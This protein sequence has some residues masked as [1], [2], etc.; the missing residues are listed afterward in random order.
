MVIPAG[1]TADRAPT[2]ARRPLLL[3][4]LDYEPWFTLN[5]PDEAAV[6]LAP[7]EAILA[8]CER[9][10]APAS[11]F[12]DVL[13]L[14]RLRE[15]GRGAIADAIAAQLRQVVG[16]GHDLQ[17]HL[18]PHWLEAT[19]A[20]GIW[21]FPARKFRLDE[22]GMQAAAVAHRTETLAR[23]GIACL[24]AAIEDPAYPVIAFRAGGYAIQPA[25]RAVLQGLIA[26]GIRIDSSVV[27]GMRK[28]TGRQAV[29]F[30]AAPLQ[31]N[32]RVGPAG[33]VLAPAAAGLLEV[34]VAAARLGPRAGLAQWRHFRRP[35]GPPIGGG[36]HSQDALDPAAQH[37][38][39]AG[40]VLRRL[41][42]GLGGWTPLIF[43]LPAPLLVQAAE[44]WLEKFANHPAI[45]FSLL[46]HPKGFS[47]AMLAELDFFL[48][49][50][51]PRVGFARFVDLDTE[52]F[53][54]D[55]PAC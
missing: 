45:A 50:L 46:L 8:C 5:E 23:R 2:P 13:A 19:F 16:R 27:P 40:R 47:A 39:W 42:Y 20:D 37:G 33:G 24:R 34:P 6:L 30:A 12:V 35:A 4:S 1:P 22:P 14:A 28:V 49:A 3:L 53:P 29:D 36:G 41:D 9:R 55:A 44:A 21:R 48:G 26:A 54:V 38:G 52:T 7:T 15:V 25:D 31:P 11:L 10:G 43:P 51:A 18:H 17:L 32:W